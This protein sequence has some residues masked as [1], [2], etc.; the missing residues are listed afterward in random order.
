LVD[1]PHAA[2]DI[3]TAAARRLIVY[4]TNSRSVAVLEFGSRGGVKMLWRLF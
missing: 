3:A 1:E 2:T 4:R